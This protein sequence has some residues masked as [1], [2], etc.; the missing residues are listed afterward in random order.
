[1][2]MTIK[3]VGNKILVKPSESKKQT[4]SGLHIPDSYAK[5]SHEGIVESLGSGERTERGVLIPFEVKVGDRV[6]YS[7][8]SGIP[9]KL[10]GINFKILHEEEIFAV[11]S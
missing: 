5:E 1:M 7:K 4:D 3:P 10:D 8:H 11:L 9:I 6:L 2:I